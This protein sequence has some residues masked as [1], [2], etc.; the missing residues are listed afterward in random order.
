MVSGEVRDNDPT[1]L[2]GVM[3]K[4]IHSRNMRHDRLDVPVEDDIHQS[5]MFCKEEKDEYKD[6]SS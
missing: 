3:W 1:S 6:M 4:S 2:R 5:E